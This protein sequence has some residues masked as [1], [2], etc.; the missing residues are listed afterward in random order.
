MTGVYSLYSA[1]LA[2]LLV[3]T[4]PWWVVQMLRLGK[5]RAGLAE[6]LG[7]VPRRIRQAPAAGEPS[8]GGYPSPS[9]SSK[10]EPAGPGLVWIHAVSVGEALAIAP[11]VAELR[12]RG[13]RVAIS[14]TTRTGQRL[15]R[16]RFGEAHVFYFPLD[17]GLCI[18]PYLRAL[19]P[20]LVILAETEFWPNF[21]RLARSSGAH[22]AVVNARISDRSF[23]RYRRWSRWLRTALEP[24]EL[25]LAQSQDDAARLR[26]IGAAASRVEVAGNLKFDAAE[27]VESE[28]VTRLGGHLR[29]AGG[30]VL[31]AGSTVEGEEEHV[32]AAFRSVLG[33]FP[34]AVLVLAPRHRERFEAVARLLDAQGWDWLRRSTFSPRTP[35]AGAPG[36]PSPSTPTAGAPGAP[37]LGAPQPGAVVDIR[38][39]AAN[40][41]VVNVGEKTSEPVRAGAGLTDEPR[42]D[43]LG[44][45]VLLLDSLGELAAVYRYADLAFVGGSLVPRGGHN[46]LEP[47]F[48][49]RAILT[50][51]HME[52]FRDVVAC[53]ERGQAVVRC[54]AHDLGETFLRLLRDGDEREAL[55]RRAQQVLAAERGATARSVE[56]LMRLLGQDSQSQDLLKQDLV[57]QDL[58]NQDLPNQDLPNQDLPNQQRPG[59]ERA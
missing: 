14:T 29:A 49:A 27:P 2:L 41:G 1:L 44:G 9:P 22:L 48:F 25:F 37:E 32:L 51:P 26:E 23:P 33:K 8:V 21:L 47:A 45:R 39:P 12:A 50:G 58:V 56:R 13:Y 54:T 31:V 35:T 36:T 52:N 38:P 20:R 15:A 40:P 43:E 18:R 42:A 16:D 55:G 19:R 10:P 17:L 57:D 3:L 7:W 59:G 46:I 11:L 4:L 30:P 24:V 6:R 5:Y 53:F 34:A 28:A